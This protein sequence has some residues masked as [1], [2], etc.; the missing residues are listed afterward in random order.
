MW[1]SYL[2]V[3]IVAEKN[4]HVNLISALK[5]TTLVSLYVYLGSCVAA[6]EPLITH[7]GVP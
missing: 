1:T 3:F 2:T 7:E 4:L 6:W 5:S